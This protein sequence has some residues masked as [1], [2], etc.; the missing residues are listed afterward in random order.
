MRDWMTG[1][2][3]DAAINAQQQAWPDDNRPSDR[4]LAL[5]ALEPTPARTHTHTSPDP[6]KCLFCALDAAIAAQQD[7]REEQRAWDEYK[8]SQ[9]D[10]EAS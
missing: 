9:R 10:E 5:D 3:L 7:R 8:A 2:E 6:E 4:D 1:S